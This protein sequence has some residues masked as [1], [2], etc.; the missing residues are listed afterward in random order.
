[1]TDT[2]ATWRMIVAGAIVTGL[3]LGLGVVAVSAGSAA[4]RARPPSSLPD[5]LPATTSASTSTTAVPP[6]SQPE[7]LTAEVRSAVAAALQA[8]GVFAGSGD[9]GDVEDFFDH[10]GPQ[11]AVL[12]EEAGSVGTPFEAEL[13]EHSLELADGTSVVTGR[14][15]VVAGD[16]SLSADWQ[17]ELRSDAQGEWLIWSVSSVDTG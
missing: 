8:W 17:I 5:V 16:E 4:P 11:W 1:M 10:S 14:V 7:D 6:T 15:T 9:L 12:E 13:D 2:V 3:G